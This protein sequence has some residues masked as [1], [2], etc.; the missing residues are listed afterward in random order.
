M[1]DLQVGGNLLLGVCCYDVCMVRLDC[2]VC[3]LYLSFRTCIQAIS[4]IVA[5]VSFPLIQLFIMI[6]AIYLSARDT[7]DV[8][9]VSLS[10]DH[11]RS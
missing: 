9:N 6:V 5:D 8:N 4:I 3:I 10:N 11:R 7:I 1:C 2:Y